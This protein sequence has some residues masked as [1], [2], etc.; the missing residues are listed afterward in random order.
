MTTTGDC[1][2]LCTSYVNPNAVIGNMSY[3][4]F[5]NCL[6]DMLP[7]LLQSSL[8]NLHL[9]NRMQEPDASPC[10]GDTDMAS[11]FRATYTYTDAQGKQHT[12]RLNGQSKQDTDLQ[13]QEFLGQPA[14]P[15]KKT[16]KTLR[17]FVLEDYRPTFTTNLCP[18]TLKSYTMFEENYIFPNIGNKPLDTI[19]VKDIQALMDWLAYGKKNGLQKNIVSGT[20][21]R[22]KGHLSTIFEI[23]KEM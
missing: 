14:L 23:A 21:D 7:G 5:Y 13:F 15:A 9:D 3:Q 11:K 1:D 2:L 18:T 8:A 20:I 17:Q 22:V 19:T 10:E 16:V 6:A 12:I 4:Q